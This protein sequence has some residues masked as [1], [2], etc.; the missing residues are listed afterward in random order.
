MTKANTYI[1][2]INKFL[3]GVKSDISV[4]FICSSNKRLL[5]I[6]NKV[7]VTSDLNIIKKH[8]KNF[9]DI[10]SSNIMSLRLLQSKYYLK[11]LSISYFVKDTNLFISSNIIESVIKINYIFNNIVLTLQPCIIKTSPRS[12]IAVI[13]IN[14]QNS[15]NGLNAKLPINRCFN[16]SR[17]ITTIYSTNINSGIFQYKN[18]Q[19]WGY[20][21]FT[22]YMYRAKCLK[23][24]KLYK[25]EHYRNI[26]WCYKANFKM[27]LSKLK[28]PRE[29]S[30]IQV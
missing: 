17:H 22:Y 15:Q 26:I 18:C 12:D 21:I 1:S 27:N 10:N 16:I 6:T 9:N 3:K 25:L 28:I 2:N 30:C 11:I 20:T 5:I 19:K 24:N 8:I 29:K 23:N 14:N 7:A 13:Q 4:D